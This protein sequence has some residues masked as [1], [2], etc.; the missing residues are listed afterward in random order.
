[1]KG[2]NIRSIHISKNTVWIG[3]D[4]FGLNKIDL[5]NNSVKTYSNDK[6]SQNTLSNNSVQFIHEDQDGILWLATNL[7]LNKFDP[8]NETFKV[9]TED[10]GLP[11]SYIASILPGDGTDLWLAT[12]NGISKMVTDSETKQVTFCKL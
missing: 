9:Y 10:D 11:T 8:I 12:R 7:G 1:M 6:N 3:T 5:E 4:L 2:N